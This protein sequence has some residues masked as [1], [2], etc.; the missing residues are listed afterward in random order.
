MAVLV[1]TVFT[2]LAAPRPCHSTKIKCGKCP[3]VAW[4]AKRTY[5]QVYS[6]ARPVG[7]RRPHTA[8]QIESLAPSWRRLLYSSTHVCA[9]L[10]LSML[11][12]YLL[13][14]RAC[15]WHVLQGMS[16][17]ALVSVQLLGTTRERG[18]L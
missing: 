16:I 5:F 15:F 2:S 4:A 6:G 18:D 14:P 3:L 13:R 11:Q 10:T 8:P 7:L 9:V 17:R 1:S 12:V